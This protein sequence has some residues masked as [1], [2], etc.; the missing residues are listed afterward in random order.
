MTDRTPDFEPD[1]DSS[2]TIYLQHESSSP[3]KESNWLPTP[4]GDFRPT[5]RM[6]Q[7]GAA[8][9]EGSWLPP[10]IKRVG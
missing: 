8:V 7:P 5:L 1:G 10:S 2:V 4:E 6:Y 9:F 3:G